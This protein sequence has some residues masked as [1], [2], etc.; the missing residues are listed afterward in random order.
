MKRRFAM[1]KAYFNVICEEISILGGK[2]IHV[3]ENLKS[4]DEVHKLV[5]EN[6]EKFPNGKWELYPSFI[7]IKN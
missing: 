6:V 2:I 5:S 1:R 7:T 3:D 4:M